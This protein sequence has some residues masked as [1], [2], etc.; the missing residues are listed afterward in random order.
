[1]KSFFSAVE[2]TAGN[3]LFHVV[4]ENDEISTQIIKHLNSFKGGRVTFIPLDRVKA[5]RV[6]YPQNSDVLFLLKK[7]KF[8]PNFNPA[9]AQVLARTVVC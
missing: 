3:S 1:M 8:A 7:V 4:V 2:V 9:F 5:P 6:T